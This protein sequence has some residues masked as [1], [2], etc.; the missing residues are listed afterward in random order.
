MIPVE[1]FIYELRNG[2]K[3]SLII[4]ACS[5]N[6][7]SDR[8]IERIFNKSENFEDQVI[9]FKS[10]TLELIKNFQDYTYTMI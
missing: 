7:R 6:K 8:E 3:T 5:G 2:R 1:E 4:L 10:K 9:S